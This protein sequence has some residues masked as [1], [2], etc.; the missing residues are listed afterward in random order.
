MSA[1]TRFP[2]G[3]GNVVSTDPLGQYGLPDP[4]KWHTF[5]DDFSTYAAGDWT[6]DTTEAGTGSATEALADED[7]GVLLITNDSAND[8]H[9]FFQTTGEIFTFAAGKRLA[10]KTRVKIDDVS[11]ASAVFGLQVTDTTPLAVADGVYFFLDDTEGNG[12]L[13]FIAVSSGAGTTT[14][15]DVATMTDATYMELAFTYDGKSE[16]SYFIDGAKKGTIAT[17]NMPSTELTVSFGIQNGSAA[18]R[19]LSMDY[20]FAAKER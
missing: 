5:F 19:A 18:A 4:S 17:T 15:A 9:D 3:V 2:S 12:T 13:D 6:I 7:G 20:I 14:T 1:P 8:D 11:L 10:F 16:I